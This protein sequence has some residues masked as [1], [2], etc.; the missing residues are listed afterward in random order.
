LNETEK[1][2]VK[3]VLEGQERLLKQLATLTGA[4]L[5][6]EVGL[7]Q[8]GLRVAVLSIIENV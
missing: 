8:R 2:K 3:V 5:T 1:D 6:K 7:I 4:N